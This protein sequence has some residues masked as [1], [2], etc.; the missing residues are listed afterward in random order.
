MKKVFISP[1]NSYNWIEVVDDKIVDLAIGNHYAGCRCSI[2][3]RGK[4]GECDSYNS[5][6]NGVLV[7]LS[8]EDYTYLKKNILERDKM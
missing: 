7:S 8:L 6:L 5:C 3:N 2:S 4:I 1:N